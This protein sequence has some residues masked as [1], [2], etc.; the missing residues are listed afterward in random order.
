MTVTSSSFAGALNEI[1]PPSPSESRLLK[2]HYKAPGRAITAR[3]LA[4]QLGYRNHG[5]VNL[6]Y[7]KLA[8]RIAASMG[9]PR[10]RLSLL[11]DF[12]KPRT[13]TNKEWILIMKPE[14]VDALKRTAWI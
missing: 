2:A 12:A 11:V 14:F 5:G 13:L 6:C 7:G 1:G 9:A 4:K 3:V 8:A 10:A